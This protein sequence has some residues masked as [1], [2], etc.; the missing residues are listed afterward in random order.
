VVRWSRGCS[1]RVPS[2]AL[3]ALSA[4]SL[5]LK[6][7]T[8]LTEQ[9]HTA[10]VFAVDVG[11]GGPTLLAR[12]RVKQISDVYVCPIYTYDR[13]RSRICIAG[14]TP[15]GLESRVE[16]WNGSRAFGLIAARL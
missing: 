9:W 14:A 16:E 6:T 8:L 5:G 4:A 7:R 1:G 15:A 2:L 12:G 10:G 11:H 13:V 3:R